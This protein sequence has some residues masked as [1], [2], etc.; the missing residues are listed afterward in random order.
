MRVTSPILLLELLPKL[1]I[2]ADRDEC[3]QEALRVSSDL[4]DARAAPHG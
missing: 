1:V 4:R 3:W 2:E